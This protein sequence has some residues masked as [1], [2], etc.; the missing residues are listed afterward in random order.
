MSLFNSA[1]HRTPAA[2]R[3][4]AAERQDRCADE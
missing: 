1:L 2:S 4:V 3:L